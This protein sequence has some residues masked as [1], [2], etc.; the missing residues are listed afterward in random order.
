M[1]ISSN[2]NNQFSNIEYLFY[3]CMDQISGFPTYGSK[4]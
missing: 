1:L 4:N 2:K 3:H